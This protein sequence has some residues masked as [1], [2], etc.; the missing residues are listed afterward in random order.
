QQHRAEHE[1]DAGDPGEGVDADRRPVARRRRV[2]PGRGVVAHSVLRYSRSAS[3]SPGGSFT[4]CSCPLLPLERQETSYGGATSV[5]AF[6]G[7]PSRLACA[8]SEMK[9]TSTGS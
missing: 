6:H 2:I 3:L 1:R 7:T 9:P 4:P 5:T 8:S